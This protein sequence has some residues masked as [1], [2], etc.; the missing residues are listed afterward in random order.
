MRSLLIRPN[1]RKQ[2]IAIDSGEGDQTQAIIKLIQGGDGDANKGALDF[3]EGDFN[4][5]CPSKK[6]ADSH[7]SSLLAD[8]VCPKEEI[9]TKE[10][11]FYDMLDFYNRSYV[12]SLEK[13]DSTPSRE[14]LDQGLSRFHPEYLYCEGLL[15]SRFSNSIQG[16]T[17]PTRKKRKSGEELIR[18]NDR[19]WLVDRAKALEQEA[20]VGRR[21]REQNHWDLSSFRSGRNRNGRNELLGRIETKKLGDDLLFENLLGEPPSWT[22]EQTAQTMDYAWRPKSDLE[23]RQLGD[24]MARKRD[25]LEFDA[26]NLC[27]EY[28]GCQSGRSVAS[29]R[30]QSNFLEDLRALSSGTLASDEVMCMGSAIYNQ[31]IFENCNDL[32][33][34]NLFTCANSATCTDEIVTGLICL[35]KE[36]IESAISQSPRTR[37]TDD[38]IIPTPNDLTYLSSE[39]QSQTDAGK[40]TIFDD[41]DEN[42]EKNIAVST[43]SNTTTEASSKEVL[44]N[45]LSPETTNSGFQATLPRERRL[46]HQSVTSA[47]EIVKITPAEP[48]PERTIASERKAPTS[49]SHFANHSPE[50]NP[51][52]TEARSFPDYGPVNNPMVVPQSALSSRSNPS[53]SQQ[54]EAN[55]A[56]QRRLEELRKQVQAQSKSNGKLEAGINE[57]IRSLADLSKDGDPQQAGRAVRDQVAQDLWDNIGESAAKANPQRLSNSELYRSLGPRP[58]AKETDVAV[59]TPVPTQ[60]QQ[61]LQSLYNAAQTGQKQNS[62]NNLFE[63]T[64][65]TSQRSAITEEGRTVVLLNPGSNQ[66]LDD[67]EKKDIDLYLGRE[68]ISKEVNVV[69]IELDENNKIVKGPNLISMHQDPR[70]ILIFRVFKDKKWILARLDDSGKELIPIKEED[71]ASK[72]TL[73]GP[74]SREDISVAERTFRAG[75]INAIFNSAIREDFGQGLVELYQAFE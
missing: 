27:Q 22:G 26:G 46:V 14:L 56:I 45:V 17:S 61:S 64:T 10:Y 68:S 38:N 21:Q 55:P 49:G 31:R 42:Y 24:R 63:Q 15:G 25:V 44:S 19:E 52:V 2:L 67:I 71:Q 51:A 30:T 28:K 59:G 35:Q 5:F 6:G 41:I 43:E 65:S 48:E 16:G 57:K 8:M 20:E 29:G 50:A 9:E 69:E 3:V 62:I 1:L 58:Q 53:T 34:E 12:T 7:L 73:D 36:S 66:D 37:P 33:R 39:I 13:G 4:Y 75:E 54:P 72:I 47:S 40:I 18:E 32:N 23:A 11:D 74:T 60:A 70:K